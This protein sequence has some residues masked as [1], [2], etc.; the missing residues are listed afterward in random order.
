MSDK[1]PRILALHGDSA[2]R[3]SFPGFLA[4]AG[5]DCETAP[6]VDQ[7]RTLLGTEVFDAILLAHRLPE[8]DCLSLLGFLGETGISVPALA[9][10]P[11]ND[12]SF[13]KEAMRLGAVDWIAD[14]ADFGVLALKLER[15][16]SA[17]R[18]RRRAEASR[19]SDIG[20]SWFWTGID[21][22]MREVSEMARKIAPTPMT[23]LVTGERG[24]GTDAIAREIHAQSDRSDG[25]FVTVGVGS[26]PAARLEETLFG[27]EGPDSSGPDASGSSRREI[28]LIELASG[29]TLYIDEIATLSD[30][31][32]SALLRVL[33][34]RT[35]VR[36]G[37]ERAIPVDVRLVAA[38]AENLEKVVQDGRFREDLYYRINVLRIRLPSLR[39]RVSDIV[40]LAQY[41]LGIFAHAHNKPVSAISPDALKF[42]ES[43]PFPGNIRELANGIERAVLV[44]EGATLKYADFALGKGVPGSRD[45]PEPVSIADAEKD[46]IARSLARNRWH[47]EKTANELGISRRTLLTK[48]IDY[49]LPS[50]RPSAE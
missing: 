49:G 4:S 37:G 18:L 40:P 2:F 44:S 17:S 29:G 1:K 35:L 36:L 33:Q 26:V 19:R 50:R 10:G 22:V 31:V 16:V 14:P 3:D 20:T 30:G 38:T 21:P 45:R 25:P 32:Q 27:R 7:A 15:A 9:M 24:S 47:R 43:Y 34:E 46:V 42:I 28:G 5:F 13:A 39:E 6:S 11:S 8:I 48:I 41:F 12:V 23:V